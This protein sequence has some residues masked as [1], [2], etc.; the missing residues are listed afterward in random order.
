MQRA[1]DRPGIHAGLQ[2]GGGNQKRGIHPVGLEVDA[3]NEPVTQ[4]KGKDVVAVLALGDGRVDLDPIEK[5]EDAFRAVAFPDQRIERSK[6]GAR[7]DAAR[8]ARGRIE[9]SLL[10]PAFDLDLKKI[11]GFR[12]LSKPR[13]GIG[14]GQ[15]E[16]VAQV[17]LGGDAQ[18]ARGA[19][20]QLALGIFRARCR[21]CLHVGWQHP[22]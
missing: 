4:E 14:D 16:I 7:L 18:C 13:F 11:A 2:V 10:L 19:S 6:Q 3:G 15:P 9:V 17:I 8:L 12:E 22:L 5:I 20:Q 1:G 21:Q